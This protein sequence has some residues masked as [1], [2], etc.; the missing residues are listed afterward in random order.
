[1]AAPPCAKKSSR[2]SSKLSYAEFRF[3][4]RLQ[5]GSLNLLK[6]R[7]DDKER[8]HRTALMQLQQRDLTAQNKLDRA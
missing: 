5:I 2:V 7:Q 6:Q 8:F 3:H 4:R 1:M